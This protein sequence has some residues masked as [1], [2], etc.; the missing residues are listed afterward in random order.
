M[1]YP[2]LAKVEALMGACEALGNRCTSSN[3]YD[4]EDGCGKCPDCLLRDALAAL[5]DRTTW[6]GAEQIA[7]AIRGA[8]Y[9]HLHD[10]PLCPDGS[11]DDHMDQARAVL[12]RLGGDDE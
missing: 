10:M 2:E 6:I 8:K 1:K 5:Q 9:P 4:M 3:I 12:R 11:D 7:L